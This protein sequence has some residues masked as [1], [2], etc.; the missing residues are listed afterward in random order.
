MREKTTG[1]VHCGDCALQRLCFPPPLSEDALAQISE[2]I[3]QP[4]ILARGETIYRTGDP[5]RAVYAVRSGAVMT[6]VLREDGSEQ[7]V[8]I[9]LPGEVAGLENLGQPACTTTAVALEKTQLC[10]MP[11]TTVGDLARQLPA[12]QDHLFNLMSTAIRADHQRMHLIAKRDARAR[13]A[14]FLGSLAD[15]QQRRRLASDQL[16]LPLGRAELGNYLGLALETVSRT[17]GQLADEG[18]IAVS[19]RQIRLLDAA[20]LRALA[21]DCA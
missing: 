14:S 9:Y 21:G 16:H 15:R 2:I 1:A 8:G 6:S 11:V 4:P 12:L 3:G 20:G 10:A 7:V 5:A 18:L 17:L 13:I 19:G